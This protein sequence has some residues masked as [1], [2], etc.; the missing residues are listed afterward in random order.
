M[1]IVH[2][3]AGSNRIVIADEE[4]EAKLAEG[5]LT[6]EQYMETQKPIM[7][8]K[9]DAWLASPDS[10]AERFAMLRADRDARIAATDYLMAADYPI[11]EA[12]KKKVIAYRQALRDLP[13]QDGAPWD[14]GGELTPWPKFPFT[15][16]T[17][18]NN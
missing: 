10:L 15:A 3:P 6:D 7:E 17:T 12:K 2:T 13:A 16:K 11:D 8:A 4:L 5:Y 14:G 1:A 9:R 18:S